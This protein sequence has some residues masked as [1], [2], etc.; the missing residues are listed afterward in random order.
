MSVK[1]RLPTPRRL[2]AAPRSNL[3]ATIARFRQAGIVFFILI[4][5]ALVTLRTPAFLTVENFKDILLSISILSIV[6]LAQT[7]VI[8][9]HGIDLSV[10]SMIGLVA[11]MVAFVFKQIPGFPVV[12]SILLGMALGAVLGSFNGLIISYGKVPP[13]SPPSAR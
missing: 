8:I 3:L 13:S 5:A 6:A 9:T 11:M 12:G 10:G 1:T 4:L 2:K 7:M